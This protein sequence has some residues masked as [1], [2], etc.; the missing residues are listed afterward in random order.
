MRTWLEKKDK[1]GDTYPQDDIL[2]T[3]GIR[4]TVTRVVAATV[5]G[6]S[7]ERKA[8]TDGIGLETSIHTVA[9]HSGGVENP[10]KRQ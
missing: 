7:K 10:Q 1:M 3:I 5:A 8:Y 6:Q 2:Q 9:T 4:G